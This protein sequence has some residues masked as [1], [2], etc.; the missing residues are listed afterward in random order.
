MINDCEYL[1][2][3]SDNYDRL[4]REFYEAPFELIKDEVLR[5]EEQIRSIVGKDPDCLSPSVLFRH[6]EELELLLDQRRTLLNWMFLET[7]QEIA[8]MDVLNSR[9]FDLTKRLRVKMADVCES[10]AAHERD[11]FDDDFEVEGTLRFSYNDENS[12]FSYEGADVY[13]SDFRLMIATNNYLTGEENLHYLELNCRYNEP[14]ESILESGNC[15]DGKSWSHETPGLF[16]GICVCHTT[17]I[18]CRDLDYPI[19]DV[20]QLND[21]WN[22]VHVRY[23]QF[24]T[25]DKNYKYPRD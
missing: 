16:L 3:M 10:L 12:I 23:Q 6:K 2:K 1:I 20:L 21:F 25:Q 4:Y 5:I 18:F 11:D 13:G 7:P 17:A 24:A 14:R 22:E 19:Q 8:R 9:L 15:D